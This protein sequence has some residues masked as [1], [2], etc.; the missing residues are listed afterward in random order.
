M[1]RFWRNWFLL[2]RILHS[3]Y[4]IN[5]IPKDVTN[6][7]EKRINK[8]SFLPS[9]SL[10]AL[11]E[12]DVINLRYFFSVVLRSYGA[13]EEKN[14]SRH[15]SIMWTFTFLHQ[16]D[17][18]AVYFLGLPFVLLWLRGRK[19]ESEKGIFWQL[20]TYHVSPWIV[21]DVDSFGLFSSLT[22]ETYAFSLMV[23][24]RKLENFNGAI[25]NAISTFFPT[26][27]WQWKSE[28]K[29]FLFA[30]FPSNEHRHEEC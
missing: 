3:N 11:T 20:S 23:I 2:S 21:D 28:K 19:I 9:R 24:M 16:N 8:I 18:D 12:N 30:F 5:E 13:I 4:A 15:P 17:I 7:Q 27:V 10:V 26:I 14:R 1:T 22:G 6:W 29:N 25:N